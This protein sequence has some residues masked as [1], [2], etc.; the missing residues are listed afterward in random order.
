VALDGEAASASEEECGRLGASM[1][2]YGGLRLR[3]VAGLAWLRGTR[4][5]CSVV[6]RA[7]WGGSLAAAEEE[8]GN[9]SWCGRYAA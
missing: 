8:E 6:G 1:I 2:P 7:E 5:R 9:G 3:V 4:G